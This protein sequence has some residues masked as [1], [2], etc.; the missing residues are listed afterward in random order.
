MIKRKWIGQ[1]TQYDNPHWDPLLQ[2][3]S[4]PATH[5]RTLTMSVAASNT[6]ELRSV[7]AF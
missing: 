7:D 4:D 2:T 3:G 6:M 5:G 1:V